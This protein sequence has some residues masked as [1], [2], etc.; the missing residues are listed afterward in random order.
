MKL[1][2]NGSKD[3]GI[4]A[5]RSSFD[6]KQAKKIAHKNAVLRASPR[7]KEWHNWCRQKMK[8]NATKADCAI[9]VGDIFQIPL[10]MSDQ[11]GQE[12]PTGCCCWKAKVE[13]GLLLLHE[14]YNAQ[15][16]CCTWASN[17]RK[18]CGL[19]QAFLEWQ[20]M[21]RIKEREVCLLWED[22]VTVCG[23]IAGGSV[24]ACCENH[25]D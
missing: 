9:T 25:K 13:A 18:I 19:E 24:N 3:T 17:N 10:D 21:A 7:R 4:E 23:V 1:R 5:V 2:K 22:K 12:V 15:V 14:S 8:A 6:G 11:G 16:I 20:W